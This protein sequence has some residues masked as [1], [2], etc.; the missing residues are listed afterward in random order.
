MDMAHLPFVELNHK[1]SLAIFLITFPLN[2][3]S[4]LEQSLAIFL[5]IFFASTLNKFSFLE[6]SH[7]IQTAA[8]EEAMMVST[9]SRD[10]QHLDSKVK[11]LKYQ[12][13]SDCRTIK[14]K[15]K[16]VSTTSAY[17]SLLSHE[18]RQVV[19][20]TK[21]DKVAHVRASHKYVHTKYKWFEAIR[22][23]KPIK[24]IWNHG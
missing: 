10:T 18:T 4:F 17:S 9:T 11:F 7:F 5:I 14:S 1:Q 3:F 22:L 12:T 6:H 24:F 16:M 19:Q 21:H 20:P 2:K 8:K 13:V 15:H 23:T